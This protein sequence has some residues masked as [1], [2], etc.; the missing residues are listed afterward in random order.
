MSVLICNNSLF[1]VPSIVVAPQ[2]Q[3]VTFGT[4]TLM[5]CVA[6]VGLTT[7]NA[8]N[9]PTTLSWWDPSLQR[10]AN[11]TDN[12][13]TIYSRTTTQGSRVFVESIL[14]MCNFSHDLQGMYSCQVSNDN[15][16]DGRAWNVSLHQ[17]PFAPSLVAY[18]MSQSNR[19][20]G[21]TV[22]M[23][24]AAYG[25]PPPTI[26][27]SQSGQAISQEDLDRG[28]FRQRNSVQSYLGG[29]DI[30][31]GVLEI[32]YFDYDDA[33]NYR[34]TATARNVGTV[35]SDPWIINVTAGKHE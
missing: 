19:R 27:F 26:T 2:D 21:F 33:V 13:V 15:G 9:I 14:K 8:A 11:N 28:R 4:T 24:C 16:D 35:T 10:L 29:V 23:L 12:S 6:F 3:E 5:T 1:A 17:E 7:Q 30:S 20:F 22:L 34:C 32:C 18:P 25:Y 31:M